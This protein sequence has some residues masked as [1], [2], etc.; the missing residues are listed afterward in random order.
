MSDLTTDYYRQ[1]ARTYLV[2]TARLDLGALYP[3]FERYLPAGARIL[4]AGCGSGRDSLYFKQRGYQ[5]SAFDAC[6]AFVAHARDVLG[7]EAVCARFENWQ[8]AVTFQGIWA[9]ASLLHLRPEQLP[10]VLQRLAACLDAGGVFYAS[11]KYGDF[12]G[13]RDGRWFSDLD[14]AALEQLTPHVPLLEVLEHW[15]SA[16]LLQR[17]DWLN[18]LWRKRG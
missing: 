2:Q 8:S 1:Q 12:A 13:E 18:L 6:P 14:L 17:Q 11:F 3:R 15:R 4:D 10:H 5:V 9:C 7:L 16:D